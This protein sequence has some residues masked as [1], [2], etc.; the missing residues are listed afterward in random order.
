MHSFFVLFMERP[1]MRNVRPQGKWIIET[2]LILLNDKK[3]SSG[4][5]GKTNGDKAQGKSDRREDK[6]PALEPRNSNHYYR[7]PTSRGQ[8]ERPQ[9]RLRGVELYERPGGRACR[10]ASEPKTTGRKRKVRRERHTGSQRKLKR[11]RSP[12]G[13]RYGAS[14]RPVA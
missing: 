10:A 8:S 3:N 5:I 13:A 2:N 12:E 14:S 1:L 11:Q 4:R 6:T 9:V 7:S